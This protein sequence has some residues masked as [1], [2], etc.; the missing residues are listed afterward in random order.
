MDATETAELWQRGWSA[1]NVAASL[2]TDSTGSEDPVQR[3]PDLLRSAL[4]SGHCHLVSPEGGRPED[5][6]LFGWRQREVSSEPI[7]SSVWEPKGSQ[8]G[9]VDKRDLYLDPRAAYRAVQQVA[10]T[11]GIT[12]TERTL[13]KRMK[14]RGMLASTDE[15]RGRH[16]VRKVLQGSRRKVLHLQLE[17]LIR[18]EWA[19]T[20]Q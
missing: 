5:A 14:E 17:T 7:P 11:D 10:H 6:R 12:M 8:V 15:S 4:T 3:F 18:Q 9:W 20:A 19:Q 2:Q 13:W 1:L 16:F